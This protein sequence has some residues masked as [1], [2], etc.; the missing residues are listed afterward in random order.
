M[1]R[2]TLS[3]AM[4]DLFGKVLDGGLSA[5]AEDD[6]CWKKEE[7]NRKSKYVC[8]CVW[9]IALMLLTAQSVERHCKN[10]SP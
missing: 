4:M 2:V 10:K 8:G 1:Y 9:G 5:W 3:T 6:C 7:R